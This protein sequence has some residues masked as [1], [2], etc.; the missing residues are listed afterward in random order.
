MRSYHLPLSIVKIS[1]P[2]LT[3]ACPRERLFCLLDEGRNKP[4]TWIS[5]PA[6][7]GKT[8]LVAGYVDS[9]A[10]PCL[11]YQLDEGDGDL[12]GFFHY[13]GL[14]AKKAAPRHRKPLPHLTPEYLQSI[15]VFTR[16]YFENLF[17]RLT[18]PFT[19]VFDNYQD[20]PD[21]S[22]FHEM[23]AHALEVA[24]EGIQIIVLS[25][26][27]PPPQ[28]AR[29]QANNRMTL[30]GWDEVRFT[31]DETGC[32]LDTHGHTKPASDVLDLLHEKTDGWAAG[33]V[34]L[35][36][37]AKTA[38]LGM[39]DLD[40][41]TRHEV[42]DYFANEI[43]ARTD[44]AIQVVLLKTSFLQKIEP[45]VAEKLTGIRTAGQM[46]EKLSRDHFF[47]QKYEQGYQYHPL[48][49]EFLQ[50]LAKETFTPAE[51]SRVQRN[52]ATILEESGLIEEA[53]KLFLDA[54]DWYDAQRLLTNHAS[55]MLLQGRSKTLEG[56]ILAVPED[57][58][59]AD[60]WLVYWLGAC[61]MAFDPRES[62]S[63]LERAFAQFKRAGDA[64]GIFL[65]WSSVI[66][67]FLYEWNDFFPLDRWIDL[68]DELLV[69][70]PEFPSPEIEIRVASGMLCAMTYR[71]PRRADLSVWAERVRQIV[72]Q[73]PSG[74]L[75]TM[76]GN[77]LIFYY[78][79]VGNFAQAGLVIDALRN[80]GGF[81][82]YDPLTKQN[83][84]ALEAMYSWFVAD[85]TTCRQAITNGLNN[86]EESGVHLLDLYL[87]A[88]GVFGGLSLGDPS[89]AVLYL[90]RM[91]HIN[92]PRLG[93]KALYHY[94]AASVAWYLGDLKQSA[95]HGKLSAKICAEMGW[96]IAHTLCLLELAITLFDDGRHDEAD[97]CLAGAIEIGHGLIGLE[98]QTCMNGAR[99]AFDRGRDKQGLEFLTRG[100]ALGAHHGFLN[101]PRW[102]DASMARLCAKALE[103]G[104][105]TE[106]VRKLISIHNLVPDL[107]VTVCDAWP[108]PLKLSTLGRFELL[109]EGRPVD[110]SGK[111]KLAELFKALVSFSGMAL[112]EEQVTDLLWPDADGDDA[113]NAFKMTLSRLRRLLPGDTILFEEGAYSLNRRLVWAD[114][115]A[116]EQMY[117][118]AADLWQKCRK[119]G[120][121]STAAKDIGSEAIALTEKTLA[122]Y[123]GHFLPGDSAHSWTV[124]QRE[125][126]RT[127]L[128]RLTVIAGQ[129]L[130]EKGKWRSAAEFYRR[131]LEADS[132]QEEFYQRLM[133][134]HQ[135]LGQRTEAL[136]VY[137]RCR[138]ELAALLKIKPSQKTEA[139]F[140]ELRR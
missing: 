4:L 137:E 34:L 14:A 110:F 32:L 83:W 46:L 122:L 62:R 79:W 60:G 56:W 39:Y 20:V 118:A 70:Y 134:C 58:R 138:A 67:T 33:L 72:L 55:S 104:I 52:A 85:W 95:E 111:R 47:T 2:R 17:Q 84:Y 75:R 26:N 77:N 11:W 124:S 42:F 130:E 87:L 3:E 136:A 68:L 132:L 131:G 66:D 30:L 36:A 43:F 23:M 116:F 48:F 6:G 73:H 115:W 64:A 121:K 10:L 21:G 128:L 12:A 82:G 103:H 139:L 18:P 63:I 114:L 97:E 107:S 61:R 41:L 125:R 50:N 44:P 89:A 38:T 93:D 35:M 16:R 51:L 113:H 105:E 78:F 1:R 92:S 100:V 7:S 91:A 98:F 71:Q 127:K 86:A 65:S 135:Q 25:R 133:V 27:A 9:R 112:R 59:N 57:I 37:R 24:P 94:Q 88:Q 19:I 76:L 119:P 90:E 80:S 129:H 126:L 69:D 99:F 101:I 74:Q 123:Q 8:T 13:L 22:G 53:T 96:T 140:A 5:A 31:R 108:W 117:E 54:T 109:Q 81:K 40:H 102:N 49:M 29:L 45:W 28:L 106:Y 15:P 120:L